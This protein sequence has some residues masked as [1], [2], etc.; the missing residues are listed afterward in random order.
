MTKKSPAPASIPPA[1]ILPQTGGAYVLDGGV[2]A[3]VETPVEA[4]VK[5]GKED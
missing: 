5:P 3:P 4:P 2:L 1:P